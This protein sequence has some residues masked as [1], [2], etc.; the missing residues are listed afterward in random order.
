M[1]DAFEYVVTVRRGKV[2]AEGMYRGADAQP[3]R[4]EVPEQDIDSDELHTATIEVLQQ[5]LSRWGA[6][7]QL[8]QQDRY[9]SLRVGDTLKVLGQ[10]L[11][12]LVFVGDVAS[13]FDTMFE[14]AKTQQATL[15]V[16]LRFEGRS[17]DEI[18][19]Y[20]W[21]FLYRPDPG[22]FYIAARTTF[23]LSRLL[24]LDRPQ[25]SAEPLPL[26][27]LLVIVT[28]SYPP[29]AEERAE[30]IEML[31]EFG[32]D[33]ARLD[34]RR[35]WTA[36]SR[37]I[38]A[39]LDAEKYPHIV[40]VVG[41]CRTVERGVMEIGFRA[42]DGGLAWER[43]DRLLAMLTSR[44][45][46]R[47]PPRLVVLHLCEVKPVD[48]SATFSSLAPK[49]IQAGFPAVLAMQYP[50][51]AAEAKVFVEK[52]YSLLTQG[53]EIGAAVQKAR[54]D[55]YNAAQDDRLFGAPVLY[56]QSLDGQL[57]STGTTTPSAQTQPQPS[58]GKRA[59]AALVAVLERTAYSF[60][61]DLPTGKETAHWVRTRD[62]PAN[63]PEM[64]RILRERML[65]D[66]NLD[67]NGDMYFAMLQVLESAAGGAS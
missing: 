43:E 8:A 21:E 12:R 32:D 3:R 9:K 59:S 47:P 14:A 53:E 62:W 55:F 18:A 1:S 10:H 33:S 24:D 35:L 45:Q 41:V 31:G 4:I 11:Y 42:D 60:A 19:S 39:A 27:I 17:N 2:A 57:V 7:S 40:H 46:R 49:L 67:R 58:G 38:E 65:A 50:L 61:P 37:T 52:F 34:V 25:I 20:P 54:T 15:S 51:P 36:D 6:L 26:R 13:G 64:I 16:V 56:L 22:G 23:V 30:L 28:P 48:Y 66:D 63:C 44:Q 29:F 5:W